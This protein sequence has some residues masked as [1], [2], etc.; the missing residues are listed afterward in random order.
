MSANDKKLDLQ[1]KAHLLLP[2]SRFCS[3]FIC[4]IC[5]YVRS[6]MLCGRMLISRAFVASFVLFVARHVITLRWG[7]KAALERLRFRWSSKRGSASHCS[8]TSEL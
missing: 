2:T 6:V 3:A 8:A 7:K 1:G 4:E 5:L